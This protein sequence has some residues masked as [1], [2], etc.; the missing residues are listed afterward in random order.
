VRA[1][2][3]GAHPSV[4]DAALQALVGAERIV[5]EGA[6]ARLAAWSPRLD[7]RDRILAERVVESLSKAGREPPSVAELSASLAA[8][9]VP[10]LRFLERGG[11]V[12]PVEEGRYYDR[13]ALDGLV[14]A[15]RSGMVMGREYGPAELRD[16]VGLSRKYLIP[17]LEYCDRAG[18]TAR[19]ATGRVRV[20]T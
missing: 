1:I 19:K 6:H 9:V 2:A 8:D 7:A 20:G 14:A 12:V 3:G 13:Q 15:V 5:I 10:V 16:L 4:V 18:I 17:F 11:Q